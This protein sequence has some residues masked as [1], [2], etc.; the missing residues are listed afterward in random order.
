MSFGEPRNVTD[1]PGYDNQP[2]FTAKSDAV[3]FTS[4]DDAGEDRHL[5]L[6]P[7]RRQAGARDE[8]SDEPLLADAHA[9]REVVLV[10]P[11]R[12]RLDAAPLADAARRPGRADED[13]RTNLK[14]GYHVWAGDHT[15]VVYVL[16]EP[17]GRGG[18]SEHAAGRRRPH[19]EGRGRR[20][21]CRA[22][23]RA[24]CPGARRSRSSSSSRTA[25]RGSP[26]STSRRSRRGRWCRRRRARTIH[27]WA[28]NGALLTATGSR[29]FRYTD[30]GWAPV[31]DFEKFG[32][33]NISR[34]AVSPQGQLARV[35]RGGQDRAVNRPA[36]AAGGS[37]TTISGRRRAVIAST[38]RGIPRRCST[39]SRSPAGGTRLAWDCA[40]GN[41]QAAVRLA[42]RF[43]RVIATDPSDEMIALRRCRTRG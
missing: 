2:S 19:G 5:A 7:A 29:I 10:H 35:R 39:T 34:I 6:R 43:A 11:R 15:V 12:A 41:G 30:D 32:V 21:E 37:S 38:V 31:A 25:C 36:H 1:R 40:T 27:T 28:P 16:G 8:R 18:T 23:A 3:L 22:R 20:D 24:R 26:T 33:K 17:A 9:R 14:V 13:L 42:E 4:T